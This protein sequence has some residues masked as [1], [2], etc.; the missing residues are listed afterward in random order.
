MFIYLNNLPAAWRIN[1]TYSLNRLNCSDGITRFYIRFVRIDI[2]KDNISQ[3][4]LSIVGYSDCADF[5]LDG[6]PFMIL[7]IFQIF[8]KV[9][10]ILFIRLK[11]KLFKKII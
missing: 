6:D 8:R 2:Y 7:S 1:I 9:H 4:T 5:S 11:L 10:K 3:F